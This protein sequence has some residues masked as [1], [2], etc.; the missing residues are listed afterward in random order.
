MQQDTDVK[1]RKLVTYNTIPLILRA[2]RNAGNQ[3]HY[4]CGSSMDQ[5]LLPEPKLNGFFFSSVEHY[6]ST[7]VAGTF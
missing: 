4:R 1:N 2:V 6:I 5:Q 3:N 7:V